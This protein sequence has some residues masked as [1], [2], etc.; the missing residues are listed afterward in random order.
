MDLIV[1]RFRYGFLLEVGDGRAA[2]S[3]GTRDVVAIYPQAGRHADAVYGEC[4]ND[5]LG[6]LKGPLPDILAAVARRL[7]AEPV[8]DRS[9]SPRG[10]RRC[11][12]HCGRFEDESDEYGPYGTTCPECLGT[13]GTANMPSPPEAGR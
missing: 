1:E 4:A 12:F 8:R 5:G 3:C 11:C 9:R 6:R 10:D 13:H 7:A 2:L